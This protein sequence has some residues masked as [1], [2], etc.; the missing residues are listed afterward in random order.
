MTSKYLRRC[1]DIFSF[2]TRGCQEGINFPDSFYL[3]NNEKIFLLFF[4]RLSLTIQNDN[5]NRYQLYFV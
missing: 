3:F 4:D 1:I 5:D 2:K